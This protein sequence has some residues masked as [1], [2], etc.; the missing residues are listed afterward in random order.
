MAGYHKGTDRGPFLNTFNNKGKG[1]KFN[2][3][4]HALV[5]SVL[6]Q[7]YDFLKS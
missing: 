7:L 4:G 6:F 3:C 5:C 2:K 1:H